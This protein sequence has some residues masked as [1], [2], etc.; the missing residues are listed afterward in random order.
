M[1]PADLSDYKNIYLQTAREYIN[2]LSS[3]CSKLSV[4]SVDNEI[5]NTIHI[6]SHSLR[7][8]SQV[9][10]FS[11]VADLSGNV[12]KASDDILNKVNLVDDKFMNLLK[13]SV[14]GLNA[15]LSKVEKT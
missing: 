3:A 11:A 14:D 6:S 9:M 1:T 8:Q 10:G 2:N 5:I 4:N 15:E 12:E 13:N 7:S